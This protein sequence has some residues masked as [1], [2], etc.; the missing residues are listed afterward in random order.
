[1]RGTTWP[2]LAATMG[3]IAAVPAPAVAASTV[4]WGA[5]PVEVP[6]RDLECATLYVPLD[7]RKPDG[8]KIQIAISRLPS[9]NPAKRRGILLTNS[10]GPGGEGLRHPGDLRSVGLPQEVLDSYD[11]IGM[12]PRG[13]AH[14]APVTCDL[15]KTPGYYTNIPTHAANGAAVRE[16]AVLA[17]QVAANCANSA[18]KDLL[19]HISTANAARDL[20]RVRAALGEAKASYFGISY[21][22][23]L[24][25]VYTTLFPERTD[26]VLLDSSL[27]SGGWDRAGSRLFAQGFQDRFPD[28]AE[29]V[30]ANH[31]DFG[32]GTTPEQVTAK[33]FELTRRLEEIPGAGAVFRQITFAGLYYDN[34]LGRLAE[35]WRDFNNGSWR[36][37]AAPARTAAAPSDN[38]LASQ[39]HV[40]CNDSRWPKEVHRYVAEHALDS[41][42]YPMFGSAASNIGPCAFWPDPVEPQTRIT[43]H[44]PSNVLIVQNLRDPATPLAAAKDMRKALGQR[45]RMITADQGG[46]LAYPFMDS[47]CANDKATEFLLTGR[48]VEHDLACPA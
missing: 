39:L 42:R 7:Y 16:S 33:Y 40:I 37:G 15:A 45:A 41:R 30:A 26:R 5:C 3:L 27:A 28:F 12:D 34:G 13:V 8:T 9:R 4:S 31:P 14:S 29:Y 24:G 47:K 21:G 46:H 43:A 19:P 10:G 38:Y 1:M 11:V 48:R 44:G 22:T 36:P 25:A 18:S 6:F 17:K 2:I 23:Y 35:T 32:L 20:D